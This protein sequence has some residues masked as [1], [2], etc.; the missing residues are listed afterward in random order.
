MLE[1]ILARIATSVADRVFDL[2]KEKLETQ[3][4]YQ[5][6]YE[7]HDSHKNELIQEL[8]HADTEEERDAILTKIYNS[9]PDFS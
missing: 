4:V 2:V 1:A 5:R 3:F 9:R 8:T 7:K 6:I